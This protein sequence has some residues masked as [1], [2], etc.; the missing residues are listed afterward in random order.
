MAQT[1]AWHRS[2]P[3]TKIDLNTT[4]SWLHLKEVDFCR[5]HSSSMVPVAS[6]PDLNPCC[7]MQARRTTPSFSIHN[8]FSAK[9]W[10]QMN[11]IDLRYSFFS[12]L[13]E[14]HFSNITWQR[15]SSRDG[16]HLQFNY[17]WGHWFF[18]DRYFS[19]LRSELTSFCI[20]GTQ[21]SVCVFFLFIID[22][23]W[24]LF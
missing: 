3:E 5:G 14:F 12:G 20:N 11:S 16:K 4:T 7:K 1:L 6:A 19:S 2:P 15:M 23:D 13:C 22:R 18:L 17:L 8:C 24:H 9:I 21:L 10:L